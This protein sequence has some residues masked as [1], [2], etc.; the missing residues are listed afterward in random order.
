M[1]PPNSNRSRYIALSVWFVI[2]VA[3]Q[4][5]ISFS[6]LSSIWSDAHHFQVSML[7]PWTLDVLLRV[8]NPFLCLVLGF[9]VAVVRTRDRRAWLLLGLLWSFS[10]VGD[11][12]NWP[13]EV[14][15]WKAPFN[16]LALV[17]RRTA[18]WSWPVW[19]IL[20]S[21]YFPETADFDRRVPGLKWVL[22]APATSG[23]LVCGR[24]GNSPQ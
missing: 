17:Y 2:A 12:S 19:M 18:T 3:F 5:A 14:M 13:D 16:H 4:L 22:L 1:P 7:R 9:Y 11:G 24:D 20:F 21:F 6:T 23:R 8:I 10:V 15:A